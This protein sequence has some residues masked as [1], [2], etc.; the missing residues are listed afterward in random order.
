MTGELRDA[1]CGLAVGSRADP[2]AARAVVVGAVV[3]VELVV[4]LLA[5]EAVAGATEEASVSLVPE[6]LVGPPEALEIVVAGPLES[7][8]SP[9][10]P[11]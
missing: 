4:A 7:G 9:P 11:S 5:V 3:S 1:G 6:Q 8:S 10:P 2:A